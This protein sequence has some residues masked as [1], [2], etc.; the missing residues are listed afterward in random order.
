MRFDCVVKTRIVGDT[1]RAAAIFTLGR[2]YGEGESRQR[3]TIIGINPVY[4]ISAGD[5]H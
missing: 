3:T 2:S 5:R 4:G 1:A